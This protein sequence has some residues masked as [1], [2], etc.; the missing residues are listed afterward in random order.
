MRL[1]F[2]LILFLI[3]FL[4]CGLANKENLYIDREKPQLE[5]KVF[6]E[7]FI[8][9]K[10]GSEFGSIF[11][12]KG[13]EFYYAVDKDG[14]SEIRY[15]RMRKGKW[16]TPQTILA[17]KKY[18]FNDPFLNPNEKR[19][20]YISD[21]PLNEKDTLNDIDIWYSEKIGKR[22]WSKP[23]NAGNQINSNYNEYY[24][25]FTSNGKMYFASNKENAPERKHDFDIYSSEKK[26]EEFQSPIKLSESINTKR[27]EADV[28]ISPDEN[29]IIFCSARKTGYG[30]GDL[31]ISFK[32]ESG[33]WSISQNMGEAINTE[34]HELC[35]FVT[36]DGKY[37]FFT[38]NQ[39][40][41]WINSNIID[42]LKKKSR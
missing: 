23:I 28:F 19:L 18:S 7:D 31:Y 41:Y 33:K 8:T 3:I 10:K 35:P 42:N 2:L 1:Q 9:T 20:Y 26:D 15:T 37:L 27:Y 24:I 16:T 40:I 30:K 21:K 32:Q 34:N 29:Y 4:S 13:T 17:D 25:S 5:K 38:S 11:N 22:K 12:K 6:A 14:K 39:D 36:H